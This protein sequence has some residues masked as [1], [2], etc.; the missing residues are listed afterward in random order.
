MLKATLKHT[1]C[2]SEMAIQYDK[3]KHELRHAC[4]MPRSHRLKVHTQMQQRGTS[5]VPPS[6]HSRTSFAQ[7]LALPRA[8]IGHGGRQGSAACFFTKYAH[9]TVRYVQQF[10][11]VLFACTSLSLSHLEKDEKRE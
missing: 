9:T 1:F 11:F 10:V 7:C 3:A 6:L 4:A 2:G 5:H 8:N